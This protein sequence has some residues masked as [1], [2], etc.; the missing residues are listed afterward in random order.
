M[1]G[2]SLGDVVNNIG[3]M[4]EIYCDNALEQVMTNA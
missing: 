1:S 2:D 4:N 3:I